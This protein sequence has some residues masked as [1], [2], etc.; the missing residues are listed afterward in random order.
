M[1]EFPNT[2]GPEYDQTLNIDSFIE[3]LMAIQGDENSQNENGIENSENSLILD[4][5]TDTTQHSEVE[6]DPTNT[7]KT[8]VI[9]NEENNEFGDKLFTCHTHNMDRVYCTWLGTNYWY[10]YAKPYWDTQLPSEEELFD[11]R[12]NYLECSD[13]MTDYT[14]GMWEQALLDSDPRS[15]LESDQCDETKQSLDYL[16]GCD[17]AP[18]GVTALNKVSDNSG[19]EEGTFTGLCVSPPQPTEEAVREELSRDC[20]EVLQPDMVITVGHQ[21]DET[22]SVRSKERCKLPFSAAAIQNDQAGIEEENKENSLVGELS[23]HGKQFLGN[24][25]VECL[26]GNSIE[27]SV[28]IKCMNP[29]TDEQMETFLI[30]TS[31]VTETE[32]EKQLLE[33][34]M[35]MPLGDNGPS[36]S[37]EVESS[38]Q[39]SGISLT[40]I[41][42]T[43]L[44]QNKEK[45]KGQV[46]KK[47]A[48]AVS[49][50]LEQQVAS[51]CHCN[52]E[53]PAGR[54]SKENT[55]LI[56][57]NGNK[58][59]SLQSEIS[60]QSSQEHK[61]PTEV[62]GCD[63]NG[64]PK[65]HNDCP[66]H[67][68][69]IMPKDISS[70]LLEENIHYTQPF[71]NKDILGESVFPAQFSTTA[72][73][74]MGNMEKGTQLIESVS[75]KGTLDAGIDKNTDQG[76]NPSSE[77]TDY[78]RM[79][80]RGVTDQLKMN[81]LAITKKA[82]GLTIQERQKDT[83]AK[84]RPSN[85]EVLK[86]AQ[87]VNLKA[88]K[89][90]SCADNSIPST[91]KA[92]CSSSGTKTKGKASCGGLNEGLQPSEQL[93]QIY[94][95]SLTSNRELQNGGVV[96]KL[97]LDKGNLERTASTTFKSKPEE[98]GSSGGTVHTDLDEEDNADD[99]PNSQELLFI[100]EDSD[101][102]QTNELATKI[103]SKQ[104]LQGTNT[105]ASEVPKP[106][107]SQTPVASTDLVEI[108]A[109][110][111]VAKRTLHAQG[112]GCSSKSKF[113]DKQTLGVKEE[114]PGDKENL[115]KKE[116][117]METSASTG[118]D[119]DNKAPKLLHNIQVEMF[120]N[121][122]GN[123][124]LFCRF[125][126]IHGDS[127]ITWTKDSK[128]LARM[129]R[130]SSDESPVS[131]AIVQMSKK[132]QGAY[133]CTLKNAYGKVSSEFLLTSDVMEQL[134]RY[135][136]AEG[137]EEIEF[138]QL[139]FRE[140][141][142]T[143]MYFGGNLHGRIATEDLH[144][145]E[146]V[147]RKAFRS[148][149]MCGLL[150]VFNPGH[151]CVLKVHNA[152]AYGTKNS[153]EL[154]QRNYKLAVQECYVQNTAREYAK[155]YA[156][157]AEQLEDFGKVPEIIP[158]FLIHRPANNIPY[159]TVEEELIGDFVKY[160]VKDGKEINVLRKD[161]EAGQKCCTFQHWV[162]EKTNGNLL[163]TDMQGVGM[164]LTD[165]G[166]ATISKGYKGFKG[167][168]S[169][170]F[171][172]QFK[173]IH[174]CNK[175]CEIIGLK[176]LKANPA[177]SKKPSPAKERT[178]PSTAGARKS[179][180]GPKSKH[181]T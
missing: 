39:F 74:P 158:I 66:F 105:L 21:Q 167:N 94:S 18:S 140:D 123:M 42:R 90:V 124:K 174:Q 47:P 154:V 50:I 118:K 7:T 116:D 117:K 81:F 109:E 49:K 162:Y 161:S 177:K 163:V 135:P 65:V 44:S 131:L 77:N 156:S 22:S 72:D 136:E 101:L 24:T 19:D 178:Q 89:N 70:A 79:F 32:S 126:D 17:L 106:N 59:Y 43:L 114:L 73:K 15:L 120:P 76:S 45:N 68:P 111:N 48:E 87:R 104:K 20:L 171:I 75:V 16:N 38:Q 69:N 71:D 99:I 146:G 62:S 132:D 159:A 98:Q 30:Q 138:N 3:Y 25:L 1:E 83:N 14:N 26:S 160:S 92:P 34:R 119:K 129:H 23:T 108:K 55:S 95:G 40:D 29:Q 107:G 6:S 67:K 63:A 150:P 144:F 28:N 133:L 115:I 36:K 121:Y 173:A 181:K 180:N 165:V 103:D 57:T 100:T 61:S 5:E 51:K 164:K 93:L 113:N 141:F 134:S 84:R 157:E 122:S 170:S 112:K 145:G 176:S 58:L 80:S 46:Y 41:N 110:K 151:L 37:T 96:S 82:K 88:N 60:S 155:I 9:G 52:M 125:R 27:T 130:S 91:G 175:Y 153:D 143:D 86:D 148:K 8:E 64:L 127:T 97:K 35:V 147:H 179:K 54:N 137:G 142:I 13:V 166:I 172:D 102:Y 11:D 152:I 139:L 149:V 2:E 128:L 53:C 78:G 169:V 56:F 31:P 4:A 10:M 33:E 12:L 168:C 85:Q